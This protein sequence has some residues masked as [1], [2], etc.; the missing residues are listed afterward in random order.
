MPLLHLQFHLLVCHPEDDVPRNQARETRH[1]TLV[2]CGWALLGEGPDGAVY[3]ALVLAGGAIHVTRLH[4][5]YG[6][7]CQSGAKSCGRR[8]CQVTRYPIAE[9]A[10]DQNEILDDIVT[11]YLR[12]VHDSVPRDVWHS[13]FPEAPRAFHASDILVS[14]QS[15]AIPHR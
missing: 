1:E 13:S 14:L 3:R 12:H 6:T 8:G 9:I 15:G 10:A 5:V 7:R 11:D 2:K 4:H